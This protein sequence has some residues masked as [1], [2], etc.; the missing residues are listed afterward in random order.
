[1]ET[2]FQSSSED[3]RIS[4]SPR[5][6]PQ[7]V[8]GLKS[9]ATSV[10]PQ[11]Q[12]MDSMHAQ[13]DLGLRTADFF[14]E[15]SSDDES[16]KGVTAYDETVGDDLLGRQGLTHKRYSHL[17]DQTDVSQCEAKGIRTIQPARDGYRRL[18]PLPGDEHRAHTPSSSLIGSVDELLPGP[19]SSPPNPRKPRQASIREP[20]SSE[21]IEHSVDRASRPHHTLGA[22]AIAHDITL[23]A[24]MRDEGALDRSLQSFTLGPLQSIE[25]RSLPPA[26]LHLNSDPRSPRNR[27][28]SSPPVEMKKVHVVPPPIDTSAP[29]RSLPTEVVRTPFPFSPES[30]RHKGFARNASLSSAN[31]TI[32][33]AESVLTLTIRQT[34]KNSRCRVTTLTIPATNDF[35]A[36]RSHS[37]RT[38]EHHF[39]ALEFDDEALFERLRTCYRNLMGPWHFFSA[40]SLRRIVVRGS[41]MKEADRR[42]WIRQPRSPHMLADNELKDAFT[43]EKMLQHYRKPALGKSRYAFVQWA[44]RLA[45][46]PP[47]RTPRID[48][49]SDDREDISCNVAQP[50]GLEFVVSWS[51]T[52]ISMALLLILAVSTA[53]SLLWI[54]LG[55]NTAANLPSHGGYRDAGDRITAGSTIGIC[56]LLLQLSGMG[57]WLWVSWLV[58]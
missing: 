36:V 41:A 58:M 7:I 29:R 25:R 42:Y 9:P 33:N 34:S 20:R 37:P 16:P 35:S 48:D 1:M 51:M 47:A 49:A 17:P 46:A 45:A 24:L 44:H 26:S 52:R 53:G 10:Y 55:R 4:D 5:R 19:R 14:D 56:L 50:E 23:Q 12:K 13:L 40:R 22:Y 38:K 15:G 32:S 54:F 57:G 27:H 11:M 31:A 2:Y 6:S 8:H 3:L 21:R 43:E 28:V 30:V 18:S 39:K